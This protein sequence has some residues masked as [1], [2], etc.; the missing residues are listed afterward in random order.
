MYKRLTQKQTLSFSFDGIQFTANEG[1]TVA[2][3]L[4][5][6]GQTII[7]QSHDSHSP[8]GPFCM[9]GAC[10]ECLIKHD[11]K[12]VQACMLLVEQDMQITTLPVA[13]ATVIHTPKQHND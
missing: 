11:G 1:D 4:L 3:A 7:R 13:D 10:Y 8:R 5:Y 6:S 12:T 2:A 9:M